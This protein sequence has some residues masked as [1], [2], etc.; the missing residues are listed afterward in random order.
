[1][2]K[3]SRPWGLTFLER[4]DPLVGR[5][6]DGESKAMS[7]NSLPLRRRFMDKVARGEQLVGVA[8]EGADGAEIR[9]A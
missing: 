1:M 9:R 4:A 3:P 7:D 5:N 8:P 2:W 6:A